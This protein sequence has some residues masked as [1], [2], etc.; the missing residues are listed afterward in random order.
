MF[1]REKDHCKIV[2]DSLTGEKA[3]DEQTFASINILVEK[4]ENV[5]KLHRSLVDVEFSPFVQELAEQ[6]MKLAVS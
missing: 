2:L 5:R 3:T 6:E 4:L 1:N